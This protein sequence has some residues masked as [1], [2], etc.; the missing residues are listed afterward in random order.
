VT[1]ARSA[2]RRR[3][4]PPARQ[5]CPPASRVAR[6]VVRAPPIE[7]PAPPS[8]RSSLETR[9]DQERLVRKKGGSGK[10]FGNTEASSCRCKPCSVRPARQTDSDTLRQA[11]RQESRRKGGKRGRQR[12]WRCVGARTRR[13]SEVS[14]ETTF[15][16]ADS[17]GLLLGDRLRPSMAHEDGTRGGVSVDGMLEEDDPGTWETHPLGGEPE[18]EGEGDQSQSR[19]R[20][21][22]RKAP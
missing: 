12:A 3:A 17:F 10:T 16:C 13:P 19:M 6:Q 22:S 4:A 9:C 20:G 18:A 11:G 21:G 1:S 8:L 14:P 2:P 7:P 5:G 15:P